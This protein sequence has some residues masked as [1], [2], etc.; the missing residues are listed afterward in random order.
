[1]K[2]ESNF[3]I[4]ISITT[5]IQRYASCGFRRTDQLVSGRYNAMNCYENVVEKRTKRNKI[6]QRGPF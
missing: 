6:K 4:A 5:V 2:I 3:S 1:M